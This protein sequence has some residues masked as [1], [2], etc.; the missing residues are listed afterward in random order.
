MAD[1]RIWR[2]LDEIQGDFGPC[3]L[4][5]GNFD[6]VH[7]GHQEILRRLVRLAGEHGWKSAAM[8]FDPHPAQ[9]L[10]PERAPRLLSTLEQRCRW[11]AEAGLEQV[12]I[13]PFTPEFSSTSPEEFAAR[14]LAKQLDARIVLVGENFRFGRGK[15]GDAE[16]RRQL[17]ARYGFRTEIVGGVRFRR[18]P[19][20]SSEVRRLLSEGRVTLACRL[21]GRPYSIAGEVVRGTGTGSRLT[22][23]TLNLTPG[24]QLVPAR[25]VYVSRTVEAE[26]GRHWPSVTN[27]GVRPTFGGARLT[28]E[29]YLLA[30]LDGGPPRRIAV[31]FL[32]RLRPERRFPDAEALRRQILHDAARAAAWHRRRERFRAKRP[33]RPG[34]Q[35][36]TVWL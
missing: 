29:S 1:L 7:I 33:E 11:M 19:V 28:V 26:G 17:G 5:I 22:V 36:P 6:G 20:S 25:G 34:G 16:Q 2:G 27:V 10:A 4:T 9:V 3:A 30:P 8:T 32:H 31:E 23:P 13:V 24:E 21:L 14:V 18:H 15:G 35:R 12:L